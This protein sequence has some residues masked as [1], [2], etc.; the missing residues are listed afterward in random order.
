MTLWE[1]AD[2]STV[3]LMESFYYYLGQGETKAKALHL[4]K[5]DF[6]SNADQ[7]KSNPFFWSSFVLMGNTDPI[8][9]PRILVLLMNFGILFIPIPI[10]FF[11]YLRFRKQKK[12]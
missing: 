8:Y 2:K 9:T 3:E 4:A 12:A 6:L 1:V 11:L 5:L 10:F 7:L